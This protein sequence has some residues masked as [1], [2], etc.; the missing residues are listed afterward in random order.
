MGLFK[1]KELL[2]PISD[3]ARNLNERIA[4]LESQIQQLNRQDQKIPSLPRPRS[5][6]NPAVASADPIFEEVKPDRLTSG[7]DPASLPQ[8]F[9]DLGVRKYDLAGMW[10]RLA[11]HF[12]G[13]TAPNPKLVT[14]L[15]AGSIQG[16]RP[17]RY[18]KRVARNRFIVLAIVFLAAMWG[19]LAM[20]FRNR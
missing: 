10:K 15:A 8:H 3:R 18:E 2:D 7:R 6:V 4:E 17:L 11:N 5:P 20:F 1:K 19:I 9:N 16:L 13:P 14:Y 12:T